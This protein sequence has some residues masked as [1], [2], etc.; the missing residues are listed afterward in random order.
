MWDSWGPRPFAVMMESPSPPP[1]LQ[2]IVDLKYAT[3]L[4]DLDCQTTL[5]GN[6][7]DGKADS[8]PDPVAVTECEFDGEFD[9]VPFWPLAADVRSIDIGYRQW[10]WN[11]IWSKTELRAGTF[12]TNTLTMQELQDDS[13]KTKNFRQPPGLTA[14]EQGR[15]GTLYWQRGFRFKSRQTFQWWGGWIWYYWLV[16]WALVVWKHASR[17]HC[18][19]LQKGALAQSLRDKGTTITIL[20]TIGFNDRVW[21]CFHPTI[22][23]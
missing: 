15:P 2:K 22:T 16:L 20:I 9:N 5:S 4:S 6:A 11:C 12:L 3:L 10:V 1:S 17:A 13:A 14:Q 7:G 18:A 19:K 21:V 8:I 23:R